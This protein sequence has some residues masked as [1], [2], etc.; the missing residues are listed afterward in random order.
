MIQ[1]STWN[2]LRKDLVPLILTY[3]HDQDLLY[4]AGKY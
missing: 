3:N 2:I 1:L 4:H